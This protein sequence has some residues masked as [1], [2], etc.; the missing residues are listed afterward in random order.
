LPAALST[1]QNL[2]FGKLG[3]AIDAADIVVLLVDHKEFKFL[4]PKR[5]AEKSVI[6]TRGVW[7]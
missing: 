3:E 1:H 4:E 6:D 7:R 5:L 2:K